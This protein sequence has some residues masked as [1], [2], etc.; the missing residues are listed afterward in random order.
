M[1]CN[2]SAAHS[3]CH[4]A[5]ELLI[6]R[7][8]SLTWRPHWLARSLLSQAKC[9]ISVIITQIERGDC[10]DFITWMAKNYRLSWTRH[11]PCNLLVAVRLDCRDCREKEEIDA[12]K[13]PFHRPYGLN[14]GFNH[15]QIL[16]IEVLLQCLCESIHHIQCNHLREFTAGSSERNSRYQE[17]PARTL[18][19]R[20]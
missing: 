17:N 2:C 18:T 20:L 13:G 15:A 8:R 3:R 4:I 16:R 11:R 14:L 7:S 6:G 5:S 9:C 1:G 19:V 10:G 12:R